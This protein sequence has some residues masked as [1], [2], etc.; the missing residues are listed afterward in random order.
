MIQTLHNTALSSYG[1][2]KDLIGTA[3]EW[4]NRMGHLNQN[5]IRKLQEKTQGVVVTDM[6]S[7][8][9]KCKVCRLTHATKSISRRTAPRSQIPYEK[10]H[11]DLIPMPEAYDGSTQVLHLQCN[12]C[13]MTMSTLWKTSHREQSCRQ[14]RT[15]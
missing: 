3:K 10:V 13:R 5:A 7:Y 11:L 8:D 6:D 2:R 9:M 12:F 1:P 14:S 4:H 15:L